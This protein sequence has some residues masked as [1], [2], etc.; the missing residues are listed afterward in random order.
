MHKMND[1]I[2]IGLVFKELGLPTGQIRRL[3]NSITVIKSCLKRCF[4]LLIKTL[5]IFKNSRYQKSTAEHL[6]LVQAKIIMREKI[7]RPTLEKLGRHQDFN[8]RL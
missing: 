4:F 2:K 6:D 5:W 8:L 1:Q 7:E 3:D